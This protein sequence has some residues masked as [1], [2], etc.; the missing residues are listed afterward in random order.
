MNKYE[1]KIWK[2]YEGDGEWLLMLDLW[3]K[4]FP[5]KWAPETIDNNIRFGIFEIERYYKIM[6]LAYK[7]ICIENYEG[8]ITTEYS[9][10]YRIVFH[11]D[12]LPDLDIHL[13][14]G[15][16]ILA[17]DKSECECDA[18]INETDEKKQFEYM[19]RYGIKFM[20]YREFMGRFVEEI[21]RLTNEL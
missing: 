5:G 14:Q 17:V 20:S 6:A 8:M 12:N 7:K 2:Y 10:C 16:L 19:T 13:M 4:A 15:G 18:E 1:E 9:N 11:A 3:N 21:E